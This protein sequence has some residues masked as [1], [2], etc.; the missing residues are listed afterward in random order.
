MD[1]VVSPRRPGPVSPLRAGAVVIGEGELGRWQRR[2]ANATVPH[3][4][5]ELRGA[6]NLENFETI[7][8]NLDREYRGRYPFLDTDVYKTLEGIAY[9]L[10]DGSSASKET[11]AFFDEAVT[12]IEASQADDGYLNTAFQNPHY[13]KTP[14][15]D[16]A[17]GHELYNLG[18]LIQAAV[19]ASRRLADDRLL[20]VARRFADLA[21]KRFG[22]DGDPE[23]CGHP[24]IEMAL[25][26]L[27]RAT[28]EESYL[29]LARLFI[30]RRGH[31]TVAAS[32]FPHDYFQDAEPLLTLPSVTGHAVRMAYLAAGAADVAIETADEELL[33]AMERLFADMIA[34]KLHFTG[35]LGSRHTDEAIGDH[36]ELTPDRSYS[37]T[38]AAIA[39]MQ[40]AWRMFLATGNAK[41]PD[42][43]EWVLYNAY[44]A[45]LSEGGTCFFYDNPLQRRSDH[46][47]PEDGAPL[48]EPWFVC[49]CCPPNVVRW[50]AE[51][52]D[53]IAVQD[54]DGL[55]IALYTPSTIVQGDLELRVETLYPWDGVVRVTV[56][57]APSTA[58]SISLRVPAWAEGA[59][60]TLNGDSET[61][62][63]SWAMLTRAWAAGDELVLDLPMP[64][65]AH[66]AHPH[67]DAVRGSAATA[68]GPLVYCAEEIDAE[69]AIDDLVIDADA[70]E[71]AEIGPY[72]HA[73]HLETA[74]VPIAIRAR[75]ASA[76][77]VALYP[78]LGVGTTAGRN[79]RVT[80]RP[81]FLWGNRQPSAMRV[82]MRTL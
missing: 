19:A 57:K 22:P 42:V 44:A 60:L 13:G 75:V 36:F 27:Y 80:L 10:A 71:A 74:H 34:T 16:L 69:A 51:L 6:G 11:R 18:H 17:W 8:R 64:L 1:N 53:Y 70:I 23:V 55:R 73:G 43:F 15:S 62:D 40:W 28:G 52:Q 29:E 67:L 24:E 38:C 25:V 5:R 77:A 78:R 49:P 76:H 66:G 31:R 54:G 48:R 9:V 21:V 72:S 4:I 46:L 81:Y 45:G 12:L 33:A 7:A 35:G 61:V 3:V 14:W 2:N 47:V 58:Q 32:I 50:T 41:Y 30:E 59:S 68:R 82:W 79:A 63:G 20:S 56:V 37:E 39:V 26:E 65:R